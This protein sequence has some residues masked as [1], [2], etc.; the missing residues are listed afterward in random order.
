MVVK[1]EIGFREGFA[2]RVRLLGHI[3]PEAAAEVA[4]TV[5]MN[6]TLV[7]WIHDNRD[8]CEVVT[9]NLDV[10]VKPLL[11]KWELPGVCSR[12]RI[13]G[14]RVEIDSIM[15]KGNRVQFWQEQDEVT[16]VGDGAN[17]LEAIDLAD[18]GI[19]YGGIHSPAS[20]LFEVAD[21]VV[22]NEDTRCDV[23]SRL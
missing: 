12:A 21:V 3:A 6:D 9:G 15:D 7:N 19:A 4:K 20:V 13:N 22:L 8:D 5:Q 17:D 23:L 18:V 10:W 16:F 14:Q 11:E 1:G 2:H